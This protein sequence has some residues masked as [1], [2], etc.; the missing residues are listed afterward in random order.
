MMANRESKAA[1]LKSMVERME[2]RL[3]ELEMLQQSAKEDM[4]KLQKQVEEMAVP[5]IPAIFAA[6]PAPRPQVI[7][8]PAPIL[9]PKIK[10]VKARPRN[11]TKF[12]PEVCA[13]IRMW[14]DE[15]LSRE[16]IAERVGCT[17]NSLQV[18]CSRIGISLWAKDRPRLREVQIVYEEMA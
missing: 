13:N 8:R 9:P 10:V 3:K 16:V 14:L 12:T 15:G 7:Y 2:F 4:A 18:S 1:L 6:P 11:A 5:L 17:M